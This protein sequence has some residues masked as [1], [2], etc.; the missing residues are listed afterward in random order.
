MKPHGRLGQDDGALTPDVRAPEICPPLAP[1]EGAVFSARQS[2]TSRVWSLALLAAVAGHGVITACLLVTLH[3][4][5]PP[6]APGQKAV[7]MVFESPASRPASAANPA[8]VTPPQE[9]QPGPAS[10]PE[11]AEPLS[12]PPA[13]N[14][15]HAA[16]PPEMTPPDEALASPLEAPPTPADAPP[17]P[18]MTD[19]LPPVNVPAPVAARQAAPAHEHRPS[20][21]SS[22]MP[23]PMPHKAAVPPPP[24]AGLTSHSPEGATPPVSASARAA[25]SQVQ[26]APAASSPPAAQGSAAA[27]SG[28]AS[29]AH[30][31]KG[32]GARTLTCTPPQT[33]YPPMARHLHEEGEGVV[34]VT[35]AADGGIAAT[36]LVQSTGYDDLDAQALAAA[37]G[38]HCAAPASAP[39][40]GRIPV[41]F[42]IR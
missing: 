40:V 22:P 24:K 30:V 19:I 34:E 29:V 13:A 26:S 14:L 31:A 2:R 8:S 25:A 5:H 4:R 16:Q 9:A 1:P 15:T 35:L 38:L 33:H 23:M 36:R 11:Q 28:A 42:H 27:Q 20:A 18:P 12:V 3:P 10:S 32:S 39:M 7:E 6:E 41:G 17:V 21:P 37:R